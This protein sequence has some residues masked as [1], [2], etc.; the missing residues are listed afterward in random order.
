MGKQ[1]SFKMNSEEKEPSVK[2]T[3]AMLVKVIK[4]QARE[5]EK[6][7]TGTF[8]VGRTKECDFQVKESSVS[9]N[10]LQIT[11]DGQRRSGNSIG[12]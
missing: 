1:Y 9:R 12:V 3:P 8:L 6:R 2:S 10:H 5:S 4:G 11:F 7:F